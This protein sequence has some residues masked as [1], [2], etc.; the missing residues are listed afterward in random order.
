[1]TAQKSVLGFLVS[2]A[3]ILGMPS[4]WAVEAPPLEEDAGSEAGESGQQGTISLR[5]MGCTLAGQVTDMIKEEV[6]PAMVQRLKDH[7]VYPFAPVIESWFGQFMYSFQT[8]LQKGAPVVSSLIT[9]VIEDPELS[10]GLTT[11]KE[12]WIAEQVGFFGD[13][14]RVRD[15]PIL[16]ILAKEGGIEIVQAYVGGAC[17]SLD[18]ADRLSVLGSFLRFAQ[19]KTPTPELAYSIMGIKPQPKDAIFELRANLLLRHYC[20]GGEEM[21]YVLYR[22]AQR[23]EDII[24]CTTKLYQAQAASYIDD[25]RGDV[26]DMKKAFAEAQ[27]KY[28]VA[29]KMLFPLCKTPTVNQEFAGVFPQVCKAHRAVQKTFGVNVETEEK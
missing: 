6:T 23:V 11:L 29:C 9:A 8:A 22:L 4:S 5:E 17:G 7:P 28:K 18:E 13:A 1:M 19:G 24:A 26:R 25:F 3:L 15:V 20:E 21:V 2:S 27:D 14:F 10:E 16:Q 12:T